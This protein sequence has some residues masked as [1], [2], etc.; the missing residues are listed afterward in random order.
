MPNLTPLREHIIPEIA[1]KN[2]LGTSLKPFLKGWFGSLDVSAA[3]TNT[4]DVTNKAYV[5]SVIAG[6]GTAVNLTPITTTARDA[7]SATEGMIIANS[8]TH[9][10]NYYDGTPWKVLVTA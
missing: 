10:L 4:T 9:A 1:G 7:L 2:V 3:P 5:D 8:T 6:G